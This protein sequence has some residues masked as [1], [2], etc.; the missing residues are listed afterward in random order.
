MSY[1]QQSGSST[2]FQIVQ[3]VYLNYEILEFLGDVLKTLSRT[4]RK[5]ISKRKHIKSLQKCGKLLACKQNFL[6]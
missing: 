4:L 3:G 6:R 1:A 2:I 5:L